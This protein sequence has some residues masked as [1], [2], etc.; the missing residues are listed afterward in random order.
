MSK[1]HLVTS[2]ID[3]GV[4]LG[5]LSGSREKP[6]IEVR[7]RE[8]VIEGVSIGE[9]PD[10]WTVSVPIPKETISEGVQN[11]AVYAPDED[12]KLADFTLIAG[13]P[14][15][16]DLRTEVALLRSE[17]DMLKRAF[18]RHCSDS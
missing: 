7:H 3:Q 14:A 16:E 1:M 5:L 10:G 17:L 18:R 9:A 12:R 4:W 2:R 8:R 15:D 13:E 6:R 11:F